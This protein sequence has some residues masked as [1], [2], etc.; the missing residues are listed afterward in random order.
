MTFH[1]LRTIFNENSLWKLYVSEKTCKRKVLENAFFIHIHIYFL[2]YNTL[3]LTFYIVFG[4]HKMITAKCNY[5]LKS[6]DLVEIQIALVL[7]M[8]K[9]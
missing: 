6:I 2:I 4:S 1:V 5:I 9:I 3:T 8:Q 7:N